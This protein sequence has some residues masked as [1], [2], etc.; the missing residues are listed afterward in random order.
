M[1]DF[2]DLSIEDAWACISPYV[3]IHE[4]FDNLTK[5][6]VKRT[7][8][9]AIKKI[10]SSKRNEKVRTEEY[11]NVAYNDKWVER[12]STISISV[13]GVLGVTW[14]SNKFVLQGLGLR[15]LQTLRLMKLIN[16]IKPKSVLD[17]GCGNGERLLQLA[18]RFP[19]VKFT[20]VDLT[21]GGIDTAKNIQTFDE[22]PESLVNI[23]PETLID[24]KAHKNIEF[25]CASAKNLPFDDNSFDL[26]YTSLALEQMELI[27]EEV[28]KEI[29][30][31]SNQYVSFYEA[32]KEYNQS[33][34]H[35]A[36]IYGEGYF[37]GSIDDL[38]KLS[39]RNI[40]VIDNI[41]QKHH[42]TNVFVVAEK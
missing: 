22:L 16:K 11:V 15:R 35:R 26:V 37:K 27:R 24:L 18:C 5:P 32:F 7:Y 33:L 20:G 2:I 31:V 42:E 10:L 29:Y 34:Q 17:I 21:Q 41:P 13:G 39:F 25:I 23:S 1:T 38:K 36:Y 28:L 12:D 3:Q 4:N 30:R 8:K 40:E 9:A 6:I 19:E 14:N